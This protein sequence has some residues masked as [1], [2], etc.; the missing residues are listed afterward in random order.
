MT[1]LA[2]LL[3]VAL[4]APPVWSQAAGPAAP[5]PSPDSAA[6]DRDVPGVVLLVRLPQHA[7]AA[8]RTADELRQ[9]PAY[10][11]VPIE[12]VVCGGGSQ[13]LLAREPDGPALGPL[14]VAEAERS[15]VR[16]IACGMSLSNLGIDPAD[17]APGVDVVPNGLLH[18]IDRQAEGFLSVEL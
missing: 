13:A 7:R 17:L 4:A 3:L 5:A 1:R 2:L 6:A 14:L 16:L 15:G 18:A 11:G 10:D 12:L 8:L 9:R